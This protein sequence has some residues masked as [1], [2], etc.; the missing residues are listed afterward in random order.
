MLTIHQDNTNRVYCANPLALARGL[1]VGMLF[2]DAR[3]FCPDLHSA[4]ADPPA[5]QRLLAGLRRWA[6]RYCPWVGYEDNGLVMDVTGSAHLFGGEAPLC[7]LLAARL[8]RAGLAVQIGLA[9]TRGA[10]WA[11]AH[12]GGGGIIPPG[13]ALDV[14]GPLPV[15]GLRLDGATVTAL[16]RLG[17]YT[18]AQLASAARAPLARRFGQGVLLRLDQALG[19]QPEQISPGTEPPHYAVRISLPEPIGH[20]ADVMAATSRLL[21][22]LCRKLT[23]NGV[24]ARILHL[25]LRRVDQHD[26][27]IELR[28]ARPMRDP[29]RILPLFQR[30][31][32]AADAGFGIDQMR[33]IASVTEPLAPEQLGAGGSAK[34]DRIDDLITRIGTRIGIAN[35]QRFVP[36]DTHIP[37]HGF[38]LV[39]AAYSSPQSFPPPQNPRPLIIFPPEPLV[40]DGPEPPPHFRWR[41][42]SLQIARAIGPERIAPQWWSDDPAWRSGIRDYWRVETMQGRRL[43]LFYTPQAPGWCVQGEFA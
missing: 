17:I 6:T 22:Q 33:L 10:A 41:G 25:V 43:W 28:L 8:A 23:D 38:A 42:M 7:E 4:P 3:A 13:Q 35:I 2:S 19:A 37:E 34:R 24:G 15:A 30:G 12:V 11:M 20:E 39:P 9:D 31:V 1:Q 36:R 21:V 14:L 32:S 18:I 29:A 40:A 27:R 16:Q 5:D 26:A